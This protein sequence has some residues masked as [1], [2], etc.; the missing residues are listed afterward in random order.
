MRSASSG[1]N[2]RN[3]VPVLASTFTLI[4]FTSARLKNSYTVVHLE[5]LWFVRG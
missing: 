4:R 2:T 1:D 3:Y 5:L